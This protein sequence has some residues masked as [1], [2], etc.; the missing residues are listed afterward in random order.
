VSRILEQIVGEQPGP[1]L[2]VIGGIHGNEP[3]GIVAARAVLGRVDRDS[4][5]GEVCA[6]AGNVPGL[7]ANRRFFSH[8]LNRLWFPERLAAARADAD[9]RDEQAELVELADE[10]DRVIARARGPV[11]ALDLHTTSAAGV[12]FAV[13]GAT[14]AHRAFAGELPLP[15]IVGLEEQLPGVLTRYL[16][17]LGCITVAIEGGQSDSADTLA[18]L[19]AVIAVALVACG[20]IGADAM[21]ELATARAWLAGVRGDLPP[22][23]D[24]VSRRAITPADDFRMEPGF[25]NIQR[26]TRGTL[27]ARDA[28][29]EIHAPFDGFVLLPLYQAQGND[30]FFYGT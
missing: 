4:I 27:L 19:E 13:V 2:I 16:S 7:A 25:A 9:R 14:A 3:A 15:G 5:A 1:T 17:G 30:G 6:L 29:G 26:T 24:V 8:D 11:F 10:L 23:I 12:P 20:V 21:P 18:N 22:M 28:H